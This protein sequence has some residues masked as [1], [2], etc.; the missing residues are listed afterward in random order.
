MAMFTA[1]EKASVTKMMI[2]EAENQSSAD[3]MTLLQ[4]KLSYRDELLKQIRENKERKEKAYSGRLLENMI[5]DK[6]TKRSRSE[7]PHDISLPAIVEE[8]MKERKSNSVAR[9]TRQQETNILI[10][11]PSNKQIDVKMPQHLAEYSIFNTHIE[12]KPEF[13]SKPSKK[14]DNKSFDI[15]R[16]TSGISKDRDNLSRRI[17]LDIFSAEKLEPNHDLRIDIDPQQINTSHEEL[18][19]RLKPGEFQKR[20]EEA[21]TRDLL[22]F[23][24]KSLGEIRNLQEKATK[25]IVISDKVREQSASKV[26]KYKHDVNEFKQSFHNQVTALKVTIE[27]YLERS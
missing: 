1:K 3:V 25:T 22:P 18:M 6:I 4:K 8:S 14:S 10:P 5:S 20:I 13:K 16:L 12:D 2:L 26:A 19:K 21:V 11:R 24:K 17:N 27:T 9:S 15:P 7:V 23:A